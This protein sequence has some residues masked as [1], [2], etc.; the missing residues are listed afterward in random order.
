MADK[1]D[2]SERAFEDALP[3]AKIGFLQRCL[4]SA[5]GFQPDWAVQH[6]KPNEIWNIKQVGA[7][8]LAVSP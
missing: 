4:I 3:P 8:S 6:G 1:I 7:A 2:L 5:G